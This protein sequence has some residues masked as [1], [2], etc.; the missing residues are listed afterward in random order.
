MNVEH[1]DWMEDGAAY[2]LDWY[3]AI[4]DRLEGFH[5]KSVR[6]GIAMLEADTEKLFGFTRAVARKDGADYVVAGPLE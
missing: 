6:D 4:V 2:W 5:L 3:R 1:A